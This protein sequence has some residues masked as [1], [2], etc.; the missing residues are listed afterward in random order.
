MKIRSWSF[1]CFAAVGTEQHEQKNM[2]FIL[3]SCYKEITVSSHETSLKLLHFCKSH[4]PEGVNSSSLY[5]A[6]SKSR[7]GRVE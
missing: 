5:C 6:A 4:D 2:P 3:C 1:V 7:S